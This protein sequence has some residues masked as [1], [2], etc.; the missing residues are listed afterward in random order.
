MFSGSHQS[1][2]GFI[3]L[4]TIAPDGSNFALYT[5]TTG[6]N[7]PLERAPRFSPN[8]KWLA[9]TEDVYGQFSPTRHHL[10]VKNLETG[11]AVKITEDVQGSVVSWLDNDTLVF[12]RFSNQG[13]HLIKRDGTGLTAIPNAPA[14]ANWPAS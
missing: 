11:I 10:Y 6:E 9:Y 1:G 14:N 8:G 12:E 5:E 7:S 2:L 13:L 3:D 4:M